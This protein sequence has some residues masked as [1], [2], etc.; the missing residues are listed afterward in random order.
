M[1]QLLGMFIYP[2]V[3]LNG[4]HCITKPLKEDNLSTGAK[5]AE[6]ILAPCDILIHQLITL[7]SLIST[8]ALRQNRQVDK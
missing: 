6:F 7:I 4:V 3:H 5:M 2:V 1:A 8:A